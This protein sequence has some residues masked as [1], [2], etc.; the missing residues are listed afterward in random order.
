MVLGNGAGRTRIRRAGT[1][2]AAGGAVL[3]GLAVAHAGPGLT[4]L[5]PVRRAA[6]GRLAGEGDRGHVALTFDDG[7][8]PATTP[9][10]ARLLA[11][12]GVTATFF[13]LGG[14]AAQAP[15]L[16]ADLAA[17]G[18]EIGVHG[19]EHRY[20]T[21]RGPRATL[22]DI[23]RA[24]DL[25]EG[26]AGRRPRLFRPPYG[27]LTGGGLVAARRLGLTPVLWGAWGREWQPGATPASVYA[28]LAAGLH[29]GVTVLLHDSDGTSPAGSARA[30]L[31]ALPRLLDA[32]AA[33]GLAVGPLGQH[34]WSGAPGPGH[35]G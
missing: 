21:R 7:P 15:G 14:M 5:G 25:I 34:G 28:S 32:C 33:Q 35:R 18:H 20:L 17:A 8:D 1:L 6:F 12:R 9:D 30:A 13:L 22:D 10:F 23:R 4:G 3:A 19:W 29:G 16:V 24:T 26:A 11:R 27:V 2:A 31:G